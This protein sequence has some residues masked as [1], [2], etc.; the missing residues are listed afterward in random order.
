MTAAGRAIVLGAPRS[1]TTFLMRCLDAV[2]GAECVTGNLFPIGVL[3]LAAQRGG[4]ELDEVL[5]R[6]FRRAL[7]DYLESGD[8]R[9][10]VGAMR[11]WWV[12]GRRPGELRGAIEGTRTESTLIYKEPFL[13]FAPELSFAASPD[14]RVVYLLRDG[15]DVADSLIRSYDV[16]SDERLATLDSN[17][18]PIGRWMSRG[19][20]VPWWVEP[21]EE[22]RFADAS[23]YSRALWMWKEMNLRCQAFLGRPE[24]RD[25]GR[26]LTVRYEDLIGDPVNEGE[27]IADHFGLL[28]T[29]RVRRR[30]EEAHAGSVGIHRR[31]DG[32][33]IEA[34]EQVAGPVLASLGY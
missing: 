1:G 11:K 16:L 28:V 18:A 4:S 23:P 33:E 27:R 34:A 15:R 17:E 12:A 31:L 24:V 9:S 26:V 30:L 7:D 8:Y 14:S 13:A 32:R 3:H 5:D 10:R 19:L 20:Y 21:G 6:S 2:P 25:S 22:E 29:R